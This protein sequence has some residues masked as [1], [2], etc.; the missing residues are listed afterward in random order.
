MTKKTKTSGVAELNSILTKMNEEGK[1]LISVLTDEQG[2]A[3]ASATSQGIDPERHSA[4]VAFVQKTAMQV[5]KQLGLGAADEVC[6]NDAEGQRLVCR[7]V[8]V[9]GHDLIL[10]VL[11]S[12]R[13]QP[14]RRITNS[15]I[16]RIN[17]VWSSYWG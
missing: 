17:P 9:A 16:A 5:N 3:I 11:M 4:V 12:D 2:L 15:A 13:T 10:A 1:F 6:L 8:H 14:Y 7:A